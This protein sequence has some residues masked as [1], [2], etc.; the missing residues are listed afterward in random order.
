MDTTLLNVHRQV[1]DRCTS[2]LWYRHIL[3]LFNHKKKKN[4]LKHGTAWVNPKNI[5]LN[6]QSQK[7]T[8]HNS[9]YM[10]YPE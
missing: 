4:V 3:E 5:V 10:K 2:T 7:T 9:S 8:F 6:E 1:L